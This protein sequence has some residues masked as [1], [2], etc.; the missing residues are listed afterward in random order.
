MRTSATASGV[1]DDNALRDTASGAADDS[2]T[3]NRANISTLTTPTLEAIVSPKITMSIGTL[4]TR[5]LAKQG[6]IDLLLREIKRYSWDVIGLAE[7]HLPVTGEEKH[8]DVT[9]LLSGRNDKKHRQGVGFL[10]SN[11]ARKSLISVTP[12]TERIIMIR[13]K[14]SPTNLTII[15]VYAPDSSRDDEESE[16]FYLQLQSL[17]DSVPKKDI[18][19]VI[20]DFN[21]IVGNNHTGHEDVM[22]KFG[23]GKMNRRGERL[24]EFCR[25]SDLV[26]TNTLFKHRPRRKT[27]WTSPDG[28]TKNLIDY[29]LVSRRWKTSVLNTVTLAGG[30]FDSDHSL[31]MSKFKT[32]LKTASKLSQKTPKF[33]VDLLKDENTRMTYITILSEKISELTSRSPPILSKEDIDNLVTSSTNIICDVAHS[34]LGTQKNIQKPW[35]T[36]EIISLCDEKRQLTNKQDKESRD[37]YKQLKRAVEKSIR[38]A[39]RAFI[40]ETCDQCE[41]AFKKGDPHYMYRRVRELAKK[42]DIKAFSLLDEHG[43]QIQSTDGIRSRWK[44]HFKNKLNL[45]IHPDPTILNTFPI[46]STDPSPPPLHSEIEAA[47]RDLRT[48]KAAGPDGI[49]PE[50]LKVNCKPLLDLYHKI[51][52]AAWEKC[53]FPSPWCEATI[54]PLH[55]KGSKA[56]CDNYRPISLTSH[57]A[58]I[59]TRVMLGRIR[60]ISS[61]VIPEYQAGFR[62]NRSTIDQIF[63]VRQIMEK[64]S[65]LGRSIYHLFID[66]KQAFDRIWREGLWHILLHFGIPSNLISL[67]KDMYKKFSSRVMT[68]EGLTESFKTS[69]GVLQGCLISPE[70]FNLFLTAALSLTDNPPG[71]LVGGVVIDK[72]AYADD[73]VLIAESLQDLQSQANS[74]HSSTNLFGMAI[75]TSKTKAMRCSRK[76]DSQVNLS[77]QLGEGTIE[78]VEGFAYLGSLLTYDNNQ[79]KD[80]KRRL[81][82]ANSSFKALMPIWRNKNLTTTLKTRLFYSLIIPIAIYACESWTLKT[83]DQRRLA[84]FETK[85][86]RRIAGITF[87]DRISNSKLLHNLKV[88]FTILDKIK[89]QQLKWLGH[90]QRMAST[91]LPKITFDGRVHGSRP[92]GRP[93]KRWKEN[94]SPYNLP[95]LCRLADNRST[96][97]RHINELV[98]EE[99]PKRPSRT[100]GT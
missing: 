15:Q 75:N 39:H 2:T 62:P 51:A 43:N 74:V 5:T 59:L 23:H 52:T 33:R 54:I 32:R 81:T 28:K 24:I 46:T 65:E 91:R 31:V 96:Y 84:A 27:S 68:G 40:K 82:L 10:L 61:M 94:F 92:R 60:A 6:K 21:A 73:I 56:V 19:F 53:H 3:V 38:R 29:I 83:D 34:T 69:T 8:G 36:D 86:L 22:G 66:F 100:D 45:D 67:I 85:S 64:Y 98:K 95:Q 13:L 47:I 11:K 20:G 48:N 41:S 97:R 7:T 78:W 71:A 30:D 16:N 37:R 4:N 12:L 90:T 35:I 77:L 17:V 63:T 88:K 79:L 70:L 14:G 44:N 1:T 87:H 9:L 18:I 72:L 50:L 93:P 89:L 25:D 76:F 26:I 42:K 49:Q 99:A 57:A 58:K 55:K 80:I